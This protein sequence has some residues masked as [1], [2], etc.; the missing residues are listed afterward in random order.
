VRLVTVPFSHYCEKARWALDHAGIPFVEEGHVPLFHWRATRAAGGG[1]TVPVLVADDGVYADSTDILR[2]CDRRAPAERRLYPPGV[3]EVVAALEERFDEELGPHVRRVAYRH[4]LP[5]RRLVFGFARGRVPSWELALL[6][7]VYPLARAYM[8]RVILL[9]DATTARSLAAVEAVWRDVDAM[10]ADGRRFL[11]GDAFTAADLT[12]AALGGPLVMP[13]EYVWIPGETVAPAAMRALCARLRATRS[14][15]FALR[16]YR[17]HRGGG[18][19][20]GGVRAPPP[21]RSCRSA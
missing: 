8:R 16:M 14:G 20:S 11:V 6:R 19:L 15:A 3:A 17:E 5:E 2:F 12:F 1:R 18:A 21:P 4:V 7:A 9:D 10:L 13:P